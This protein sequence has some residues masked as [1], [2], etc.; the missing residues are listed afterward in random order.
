MLDERA[1]WNDRLA[2]TDLKFTYPEAFELQ[3]WWRQALDDFGRG[4]NRVV[5]RVMPSSRERMLRLG[6]KRDSEVHH[7]AD[8][9]TRIVL[10]VDCWRWQMPLVGSFGSD[11]LKYRQT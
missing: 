8:G 3:N 2:P 5:T 7:D 9:T 10:Y 4:P 11:V 6:L 1:P